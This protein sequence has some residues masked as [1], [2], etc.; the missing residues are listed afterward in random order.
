MF[1]YR[2][3]FNDYFSI[4]IRSDTG[5]YVTVTN[6]MNA[7]GLGAFDSTGATTVFTLT[8]DVPA[9][10]KSI[11]YDIGISNVAD[12][13]YDS[14]LVVE[15]VGENKCDQCDSCEACPER[16][17]CQESCKN[18]PPRSC[19]F[20]ADCAEKEFKCGASGY[21]ILYGQKNCLAFDR[22]RNFFTPQGQ[23]FIWGTMSCLQQFLSPLIQSCGETCLSI[24]DKAFESHP[25]CYTENGFCSLGCGDIL[26]LLA[27]VRKDLF[28]SRKQIVET[29]VICLTKAL[30]T[31]KG[32]AGDIL[33]GTSASVTFGAS[34]PWTIAAAVAGRYLGS[35]AGGAVGF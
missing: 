4:T 26:V 35:L 33:V 6:S 31:L 17:A 3:Q 7:L 15:K 14:S 12:N 27:V 13:L 20:Y 16:P 1:G 19:A 34:I 8:L 5:V 30:D 9:N 11:M 23:N 25:K 29:G 18:P 24:S 10:T 2:T 28:E 21:P 22:N 32:C